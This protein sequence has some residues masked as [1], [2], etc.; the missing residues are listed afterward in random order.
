MMKQGM[1]GWQTA[2]HRIA[3]GIFFGVG[4]CIIGVNPSAAQQSGAPDAGAGECTPN[5]SPHECPD[6]CPRYDTCLIS[7]EDQLYYRVNNQ[8]FECDGFDCRAASET[9]SDYCCSRGEFAPSSGGGGGCSLTG[10]AAAG[11]TPRAALGGA[12]LAALGLAL[13]G[14]RGPRGRRLPRPGSRPA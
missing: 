6:R 2:L 11:A 12:F 10:R 7:E 1:T 8:R 3:L 5:P 13:A 4:L 9:L 14:R